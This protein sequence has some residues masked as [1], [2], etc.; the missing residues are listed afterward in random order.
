[1]S[2]PNKVI[3]EFVSDTTQLEQ[4]PAK[5][6]AVTQQVQNSFNTMNQ[7]IQQGDQKTVEANKAAEMSFK[8]IVEVIA[9]QVIEEWNQALK[10]EFEAAKKS[11]Q[12]NKSLNIQL[13]E[14][15]ELMGKL[16]LEGKK[17]TAEYEN[18][19]ANA[20]KLQRTIKDLNE[21][22]T[23]TSKK[24]LGLRAA[25]E[26]IRG[27]VGA[28]ETAISVTALFGGKN[29][30]LEESLKRIVPLMGI[31]QGLTEGLNLLEEEG[32]FMKGIHTAATYAYGTA[33][34]VVEG[35]AKTTGLSMAASWAVATAG[36]SVL[37]AI[38][39]T[40]IVD[41]KNASDAS[42]EL[43]EAEQARFEA[44]QKRVENDKI[45][46][47]NRRKERELAIKQELNY[48]KTE[49]DRLRI[50]VRLAK[51][52]QEA[53][54]SEISGLEK[55]LS[56]FKETEKG[57]TEYVTIYRKLLEA[58][59]KDIELT[60]T[61]IGN[62]NKLSELR[63]KKQ[64]EEFDSFLKNL[65]DQINYEREVERNAYEYMVQLKKNEVEEFNNVDEIHLRYREEL[66]RLEAKAAIAAA[67][68]EI[69]TVDEK[70]AKVRAIELKL[71]QDLQALDDERAQKKLQSAKNEVSI[72]QA[73][74]QDELDAATKR[75]GA[76]DKQVFDARQKYHN[77]TMQNI[78]DEMDAVDQA[79]EDGIITQEDYYKEK[80]RLDIAFR[81]EQRERDNEA[82]AY[83]K[84]QLDLLLKESI[85]F[86]QQASQSIFQILAQNRQATLDAELSSLNDRKN[87]QLANE[88]LTAKQRAQIEESYRK[89]E[90]QLKLKAW[91]ADRDAKVSEALING[92]LAV[93]NILAT[94]KPSTWP[95]AI[96]FAAASTALQ[97]GVIASQKPPQFAK[98]T[99]DAPEG[100]ALVGEEG[101]ELVYL[102]KG[103]KVIT[104]P[105]TMA[106][107]DK[108]GVPAIPSI[109]MDMPAFNVDNSNAGAQ[110]NYKKL[111]AAVANAMEKNPRVMVNIDKAGLHTFL[112]S[113]NRRIE[114]LNNRYRA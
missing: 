112:L 59:E 28:Y 87:K 49:E 23:N 95:I 94:A 57:T 74:A 16:A 73:N 36:L 55:L 93:T 79:Y 60:G 8:K 65:N 12:A 18:A 54:N 72:A 37:V 96:P 101:P 90:A 111:G 104:H 83:E 62:E 34:K 6:N 109:S 53:N 97:V 24:F 100:M 113:K 103:S 71:V 21:D 92:A 52:K 70:A 107:M 69:A 33:L 41:L 13:R 39:A 50:G 5:V 98:G 27:L 3:I 20:A 106:I 42:K 9:P 2:D 22:L 108:Y 76:T 56:M 31:V 51:E 85:K 68:R 30:E 48:A 11:E 15:R 44:S 43:E 47:D 10:E 29:G 19:R 4:T 14:Q 66:L 91:L 32:A 26:G 99:K 82:A 67:N 110:I 81:K 114:R 58:K 84:A 7:Q 102:N 80:N 78:A 25:G 45:S 89:K 38:I 88:E 64:Q 61:I 77:D 46:G 17:N 40:L 75:V 1:M 63:K 35:I 86:A 105:E